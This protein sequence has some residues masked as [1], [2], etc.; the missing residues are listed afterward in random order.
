MGSHRV[1]SPIAD[2]NEHDTPTD[3]GMDQQAVIGTRSGSGSVSSN[4]SNSSNSSNSNS[5]I[6]CRADATS[7]SQ[8]WAF[9]AVSGYGYG[10]S[11]DGASEAV[12]PS[13]HDG[14]KGS[15]PAT[16]TTVRVGRTSKGRKS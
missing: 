4:T 11:R 6:L 1:G 15:G 10:D 7:G 5:N 2:D 14:Q 9:A 13:V 8:Q 12:A 3:H 16:G